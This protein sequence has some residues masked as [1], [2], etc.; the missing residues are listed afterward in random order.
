MSK[1]LSLSL[2]ALT[3]L[4]LPVQAI[5][6]PMTPAESQCAMKVDEQLKRRYGEDAH[7]QFSQFKQQT[8]HKVSGSG[9]LV[10]E[11]KTLGQLKLT[12]LIDPQTETIK[13][14]I[15]QRLIK[16]KPTH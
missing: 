16:P 14:V 11:T 3:M 15:Y 1:I 4:A 2:L 9:Q 7:L 5:V 10:N 6:R 8:N 13:R 12:C